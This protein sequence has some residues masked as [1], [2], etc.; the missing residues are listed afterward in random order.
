MILD[1]VEVRVLG[2]LAEKQLTTPDYYPLSLNSLTNACNQKSNRNP[3]VNYTEDTV[4]EALSRLVEKGLVRRVLGAGSRVRKYKHLMPETLHLDAAETAVLCILMLRGAQTPGEIRSRTGRM[5]AFQ[6]LQEVEEVLARLAERDEGALAQ[7][8][9][10][11]PGQKENRFVH[12]L[13]GEPDVESLGP[14]DA[15]P[16]KAESETRLEVLEAEFKRLRDEVA[17]LRQELAEFRKE[18]E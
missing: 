5:H 9:P 2:S 7:E 16:I 12:L 17:A 14:A 18:L 3:V 10:R 11:V 4:R 13:A 6:S 1:P 8:L 15:A